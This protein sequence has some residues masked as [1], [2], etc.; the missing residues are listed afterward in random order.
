MKNGPDFE[1]YD[2]VVDNFAKAM[3][4]ELLANYDKGD[5]EP[6]HGWL[7]MDD[8][9]QLNE[10]YYHVG[11]LQAALKAKNV[12]LIKELSADVANGALM[13]YDRYAPLK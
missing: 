9:T 12:E 7:G 1:M 5:R 8:K 11:K 6:P 4:K 2:I 3:K 10:L 13:V